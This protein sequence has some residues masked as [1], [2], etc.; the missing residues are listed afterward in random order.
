MIRILIIEYFRSK[1]I[2]LL[3]FV[4]ALLAVISAINGNKAV[5]KYSNSI[6]KTKEF[7]TYTTNKNIKLH[8]EDLGLLLYY[9]Q[10]PFIFKHNDLSVL[11]TRA[12]AF[13]NNTKNITIRGLE[14]QI[15]DTEYYNPNSYILGNFDYKFLILYIFPLFIIYLT[16][17]LIAV[18]IEKRR[19]N[20]IAS[21]LP[22]W[23]YVFIRYA[24]VLATVIGLLVVSLSIVLMMC[25]FRIHFDV[26]VLIIFIIL[27]FSFWILLSM[28]VNFY[29]KN[30]VFNITVLIISWLVLAFVIPGISELFITTKHKDIYSYKTFIQQ[31]D[32]YHKKWD[33]DKLATLKK[34]YQEYPQY[35]QFKLPNKT[36]SWLWYYAMQNAGDSESRNISMKKDEMIYSRDKLARRLAII[37]P[38]Q[39]L[40]FVFDDLSGTSILEYESYKRATFNYHKKLRLYFYPKIFREE[41][42][43]LL[44]FKSFKEGSFIPSVATNF[45]LLYGIATL[46]FCVILILLARVVYNFKR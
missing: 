24:I 15:H 20:M 32:G 3:L 36:F 28:V 41:K 27:Y 21:T 19:L 37:N 13:E 10:F 31:R 6:A 11:N 2:L 44:F 4:V 23:K 14:G 42:A 33:T 5:A 46:G 7:Y 45:V 29:K 9:Q 30:A 38:L 40:Q 22:F 43:Q 26:L 35:A 39:Q 17:D 1:R 12:L 8:S 18:E 16:F 34:F 25:N